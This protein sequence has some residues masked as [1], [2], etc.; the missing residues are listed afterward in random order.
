MIELIS[1]IT[2]ATHDMAR[3]VRF[4]RE[5]GFKLKYGGEKAPFTSFFAGTGFVNLTAQPAE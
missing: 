4:Y 2:F 5:L 1:A 3:A